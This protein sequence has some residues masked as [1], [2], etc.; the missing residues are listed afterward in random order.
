MNIWKDE[1]E[2]AFTWAERI[3]CEGQTEA[4]LKKGKN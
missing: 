2:A 3:W 1:D 4:T